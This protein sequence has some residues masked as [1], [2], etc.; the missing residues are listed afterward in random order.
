VPWAAQAKP[1]VMSQVK[2]Y[3]LEALIWR[4]SHARLSVSYWDVAGRVANT[5]NVGAGSCESLITV[6]L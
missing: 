6:R 5:A 1:Q 3:W 4:V 2:T